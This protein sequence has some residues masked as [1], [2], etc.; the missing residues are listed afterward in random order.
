[1]DT[2]DWLTFALAA[3]GAVLSS[4]VA[5]RQ[6]RKDRINLQVTVHTGVWHGQ[7]GR[8]LPGEA[9]PDRNGQHS[10]FSVLVVEAANTGVRPVTVIASGLFLPSSRG[11]RARLT[12]RREMMF[13]GPHHLMQTLPYEIPPNG[14][15]VVI[16][17]LNFFLKDLDSRG[18]EGTVKLVGFYQDAFRKIHRSRHGRLDTAHWKAQLG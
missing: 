1:M 6:W 14:R 10:L 17:H 4:V 11:W 18:L 3:Y 5:L 7:T 16:H 8:L 2:T 12:R 9:L 13:L 15:H